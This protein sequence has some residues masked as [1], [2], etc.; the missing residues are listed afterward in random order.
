MGREADRLLF[1]ES[2]VMAPNESNIPANEWSAWDWQKAKEM[3][4]ETAKM[5]DA[6]LLH[7][8]THPNNNSKPSPQDL[9]FAG[10]LC[11]VWS[12][13]AE[14]CIVTPDP[15]RLWGHSVKFGTPAN[16]DAKPA[17]E[18]GQFFSWRMKAL[19]QFRRE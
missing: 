5:H 10:S 16:P 1:I 14:F 8:H 3:A 12:Q 2:V 13:R 7:F 6:F 15:L 19:K 17:Y 4:A 9:V 11:K 18:C